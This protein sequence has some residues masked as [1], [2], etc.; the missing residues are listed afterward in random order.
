MPVS[1]IEDFVNHII[2]Y[3]NQVDAEKTAVKEQFIEEIA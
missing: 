2:F 3:I 1:W